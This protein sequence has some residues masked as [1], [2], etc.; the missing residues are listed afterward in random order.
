MMKD[1]LIAKRRTIGFALLLNVMFMIIFVLYNLNSGDLIYW[2]ILSAVM[3]LGYFIYDYS[4]YVKKVKE[5]AHYQSYL[6]IE[7]YHLPDKPELYEKA[8]AKLLQQLYTTH[9]QA[10]TKAEQREAEMLDY[11]SLWV[12]QIKTPI[13]A[14]H[15]NL[16]NA[17][18]PNLILENELFKIEQYVEMVLSYL[19]L[20]SDSSDYRFEM[21]E[22][23]KVLREVIHKYSRLFIQKRLSL[24]FEET[25]LEILSDEKWL[26][27]IF[28]QLLSNAIKYTYQGGVHIYAKGQVLYI[29]D[30]GIGIAA[31]DL[32]RIFEKGYTGYNGRE[33]KKSTGIGLYLVKEVTKR[34]GIDIT[35]TST[36]QQGTC[37]AL[38]LEIDQLD[39]E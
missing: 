34:L 19:R 5:L 27:F 20:E 3:T 12:H 32:P 31:D 4:C 9:Q 8:Y 28:E 1:Y 7:A 16:Q 2:F 6:D 29:E 36:Y 39:V 22:V 11:Y 38:N 14:M 18:S 21:V 30:S 33:D 10:L 23:D 35:M 13:A 26:S 37:V 25:H 15:L 24:N 17:P